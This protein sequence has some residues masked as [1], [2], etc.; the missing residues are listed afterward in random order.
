MGIGKGTAQPVPLLSLSEIELV[1]IDRLSR[2]EIIRFAKDIG[3]TNGEEFYYLI[4]CMS[5]REGR[6]TC[7]N[8]FES[9][10]VATVAAIHRRLVIHLIHRMDVDNVVVPEM[11]ALPCPSR[12]KQRSNVNPISSAKHDGEE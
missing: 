9:L 4:P 3:F 5:L 6:R 10:G 1:D 7:H 12:T 8:D 2:F 11:P